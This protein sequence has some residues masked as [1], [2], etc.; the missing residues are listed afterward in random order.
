MAIKRKTKGSS[1]IFTVIMF[2][3]V[4]IVS[5]AMISMVSSNYIERVVE[6]KRLENL[7]GAESGLDTAYNVVVK[8]ID[9]ANQVAYKEVEALKNDVKEMDFVDYKNEP[10]G[11]I[12]KV[13]YALYADIDYLKLDE[14]KNTKYIEE[15]NSLI[16]KVINYEFRNKFKTYIEN[17]IESNVEGESG[18]YWI[19]LTGDEPIQQTV[20][21]DGANIKFYNN[22][23]FNDLNSQVEWTENGEDSKNVIETT[24]S[25]KR[26]LVVKYRFGDDGEI[27][28]EPNGKYTIE[29]LEYYEKEITQIALESTFKENNSYK[30][31]GDNE[32]NLR[33]IYTLTVPNYYEVTFKNS[34]VTNTT[35][36]PG[37]TIG[38]SLKITNSNLNVSGDIM[39]EGNSSYVKEDTDLLGKYNNGIYINNTNNDLAKE[40]NF[41]N[42]IY[43]RGAITLKD[44]TTVNV[45][46]NVY[47]Q[48]IYIN[49]KNDLDN[50]K[51]IL[52]INREDSKLVLDNDFEMNAHNASVN[53]QKFY[54]INDKTD[55]TVNNTKKSSS[56]LINNIDKN[57]NS[58]M[59]IKKD[60]YIRGIAHINTANGYKTGE[61]V[62]V[63]GNYNAYSIPIDDD[64]DDDTFTYDA[65]L[66]L[67]DGNIAKKADHFYKYWQNGQANTEGIASAK[68]EID[69]GGVI[70]NEI[71]NVH[72]IGSIVYGAVENGSIV[73]KIKRPED[74]G[75]NTSIEHEIERQQSDYAR[76]VGNLNIGNDKYAE[77]F[78]IDYEKYNTEKVDI[79]SIFKQ[80]IGQSPNI[81][82][83]D[84]EF[85]YVNGNYT[86]KNNPQE[87]ITKR[88]G[89]I[90][91][92]GDLTIEGNVEI[93][94]DLIVLGNLNVSNGDVDI[95]Y[96]K[97]LTKDIQNR[98]LSNFDDI[99]VEGYGGNNLSTTVSEK[100]ESNASQF[101]T[102]LWKVGK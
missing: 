99:F 21:Y 14:D 37:I 78:N 65:P 58:F 70:F 29:N 96:N 16:D 49:S 60:A 8:T 15:D 84:N 76:N 45:N 51:S 41:F 75:N 26:Q 63:K 39:V 6:G 101:V 43:C 91:I 46:K 12:K 32:R 52:N 64:H 10:E 61:S 66:Q 79:S 34:I 92:N 100:T 22:N 50:K 38:G 57:R 24:G 81:K 59:T 40:I 4:L 89:I 93:E 62:A 19:G 72:S 18:K 56:I 67:L 36:I 53:I 77:D 44:N 2:M 48:N 35:D 11:S 71:D 23:N 5:G 1:L 27:I 80:T 30:R 73:K 69:Y 42:N 102:K 74:F 20:K 90:I 85:L 7:Y 17:N 3:F 82:S 33:V 95:K 47:A 86:I 28:T 94:G 87:N 55:D 9:N 31:V 83:T 98:N 25:P 13:L 97:S 88:K 68:E 54:G